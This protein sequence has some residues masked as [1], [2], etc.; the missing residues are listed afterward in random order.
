MAVHGLG[1]G[2]EDLIP[3]DLVDA[4]FDPTASEDVKESAL[5]EL[6][7]SKIQRDEN[8]PRKEFS[9]E[10]LKTLSES[11]KQHGVLQ[12]AYI[13]NGLPAFFFKCGSN[14]IHTGSI[15]V[16]Y[17]QKSKGRNGK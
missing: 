17:P 7:L 9:E 12:L 11:I 6:P 14:H 2:F 8:Q 5:V 4:D 15:I 13:H 10:S 1:R 16:E 3:T